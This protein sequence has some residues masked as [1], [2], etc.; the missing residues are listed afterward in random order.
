MAMEKGRVKISEELM[1]RVVSGDDDAFEELYY[2]TYRP[3][4][5]FLLSMTMNQ[6][7]AEDIMQE[8]YLRI[9]AAAHLYKE[10]GNPMAWIMKI[11]KNLY[12]MKLR[13]EKNKQSDCFDDHDN[14][15]E[16]SM[17]NISVAEDRLLL[18]HLFQ[19]ISG[20]ERDIIIM[21]VSMGWK[22]KEIADYMHIP[23]G[24]VLSKYHR[25]MRML[26]KIMES[27]LKEV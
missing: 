13:G 19:K 14:E 2:L 21:H 27:E 17:D 15:T 26:Q 1:E 24:T 16:L 10:K 6:Q 22:Y 20:E 8:T 12:L 9:R 25:A 7:D 18:Q 11:G 23:I 5:A 3:L 4:Y